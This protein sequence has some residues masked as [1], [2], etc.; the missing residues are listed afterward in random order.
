MADIVDSLR[1]KRSK[2]EELLRD[3]DRREGE[4]KALLDRLKS[5]FEVEGIAEAE[6]RLNE[7][8][9]ELDANEDS[10]RKLDLEMAAI[11]QAAEDAKSGE[12][13]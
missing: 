4:K 7:L 11:L 9:K 8:D 6:A 12:D 1:R 2:I 10:M 3:Q 5:D 13:S